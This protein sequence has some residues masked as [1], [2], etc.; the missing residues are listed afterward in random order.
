M[1]DISKIKPLGSNTTYN[2]K[3]NS[4]IANITRSGTTFTATRRDGTTFTF[5]QQ[6]NNTWNS[7]STSQ[8]G[9]VAKAPN[10]TN[11]FLRGD[12]TWAKV[13]WDNIDGKPTNFSPS[14]HT[15]AT[16]LDIDTGTSQ[17]TLAYG[18]KYKLTTG[19][20]S[21]IFTMPSTDDT[22]THWT[23][24]LYLGNSTIGTG[25]VSSDITNGNVYLRLYDE[26]TAR[27]NI[28]IIG[29]GATSV[30]GKNGVITI[31]ST[32]TNTKVTSVDNHYTPTPNTNSALSVSAS[33][34]T[35][36]WDIDVVKAVQLQRDA[37]GHVT[38]ISV[39]SGK[40][41]SNPNTDY[42]VRQTNDNTNA[43]YRLLLSY[44]ANDTE[45]DNISRKNTNLRYNPSINKLSTGNLDLTGNLQVSG[46][47]TLN[48]NTSIENAIIN[49]LL[50]NGNSNFINNVNF[51]QIPTAP[52]ATAGTSTTQIATTEFVT[53][54]V[55]Q[56]FVANDAMVFKGLIGSN[57][58]ITQLPTSGYNA[59]WTYR[60]A[61]AGI[62]A[63]EYCEVGDLL[64]AINDGPASGSSVI[65]TDWGKVEHN[66]DGAVFRGSGASNS[67]VGSSTQP[68]YVNGSGI[69]T[70]ITGAIAN[71]ITGNAATATVLSSSGTTNQFWRGDNRWSDTLG[72]IKINNEIKIKGYG[73]NNNYWHSIKDLATVPLTNDRWHYLPNTTGWIV[74]SATDG[75]GNSTTPIYID[76]G[77]IARAI[78]GTISNN[79]TGNA[80]T[81]TTA[82]NATQLISNN[83][84]DYGWNGINYFNI[85]TSNQSA[86]KVNDT[87]FS[88][89]VWTHILR[90][91]RGDPNGYYTDLAI[92]FDQNSIYYKRIAAGS[93]QNSTTNGGWI[94]VLDQL[95]YTSYTVT[96]T[97]SGASGTWNIN[98]SGNAAAASKL[99]NTSKIGDT[100]KPVYFKADGTP[101]AIN[102]T[103]DKAVPSNAV[104]TDRYVNSATFADD[105]TNTAASPVKMTLTRAGSDTATVTASIPKVSSSS[106][107]VAPKGA[108]VSSQNQSTKFLR[109][110]GTWAAPS[111]TVNT[112]TDTLVKQTAKSDNK[113]YK[114]LFT[115]SDSPT[116]GNANEAAYDTDITINPST[117][118]LTATKFIGSL[119][120]NA[121]T[122]SRATAD[123]NG[124]II[125]STYKTKQT[126]VS[127]PAANGTSISFISSITQDANGNITATKATI[128]TVSKTTNGLVPQLPNE[129]TTTKFLRQDGSWVV[130]AA[131]KS[132]TLTRD[133]ETTIATIGGN[134]IKI[135]LPPSDNT[136]EK[137]KQATSTD[138][139]Y[140]KILVSGGATYLINDN[141][142]E[143]TDSVYQTS[144]VMVQ[145]SSGKLV[146]NSFETNT[147]PSNVGL[148]FRR[149]QIT[150]QEGTEETL[151]AGQPFYGNSNRYD[152]WSYPP[153]SS[154]GPSTAVNSESG[155][156][157]IMN[158]RLA[159][160]STCFKDI[161]MSPNNHRIYTRSVNH[162]A[163]SWKLI[164]RSDI[165]GAGSITQP[166]YIS[167]EGVAKPVNA[168][169][170]N[171][172]LL[173]NT[174]YYFNNNTST[175]PIKKISTQDIPMSDCYSKYDIASGTGFTDLNL[176]TFAP[177]PDT[178]Y[179]LSFYAKANY[180]NIT[181]RTHFYP[182]T[183]ASSYNCQGFSTTA[184]NDG[185]S[186]FTVSTEWKRYWV[187]YKTSASV[188]GTK[189][190]IARLISGTSPGT[191]LR[192]ALP[193]LEVGQ[194]MTPWVPHAN[195][196]SQNKIS[197]CYIDNH[198]L[199]N[200]Q[201]HRIATCSVGTTNYDDRDIILFV[202]KGYLANAFGI[203]K[204]SVRV[205]TNAVSPP[206]KLQAKWLLRHGFSESDCLIGL[207]RN[208]IDASSAATADIY[209]KTST[210]YARIAF[211]ALNNFN[212]RF[213]LFNSDEIAK[214]ENG[215]KIT[216]L[217]NST[218][219]YIKENIM[220]GTT[221]ESIKFKSDASSDTGITYVSWEYAS[222]S[223]SEKS[224]IPIANNTYDLGSS[225]LKWNNI[226]A[227]NFIGNAAT[228]TALAT[229]RTLKV[230][231]ASTSASTVFDGS[232]NINDIGVSGTLPVAQGGT[233]N[234][235]LN[236]N[237]V[238]IGN[239]ISAIK[240][241]S[242]TVDSNGN[243][244]NSTSGA[245]ITTYKVTNEKGSVALYVGQ[246][247]GL[248]DY[249]K[250][251]W[252]ICKPMY[253]ETNDLSDH[254][255]INSWK[256]IGSAR[257]SI[258][259]NNN[260]EPVVGSVEF[261]DLV[262]NRLV[263]TS[264]INKPCAGYHYAN[265]SKIAVNSTS[266]PS[267]NFYVNGTSYFNGN[268]THN[269]F[270]Y[271]ANG[272]NYYI[273]NNATANLK[274][275][276]FAGTSTGETP[277]ENYYQTGAIEIRESNRVRTSQTGTA[278]APRIGFHWGNHSAAS[279]YY[280]YDGKFYLRKTNG[281]DKA[282]LNANLEGN[283]DTATKATQDANGNN[284]INT[285]LTKTAGVTNITWDNT[286]KKLIKTINNS[287]SDIVTLYAANLKLNNT[288]VY[289]T[290]LEIKNIKIGNGS[291]STSTKNV[292]LEYNSTLETLNFVFS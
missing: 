102:Y 57:Q 211:T 46:N 262:A 261:D 208:L 175:K 239:G 95:N 169:P 77:G 243:L 287:N 114:I 105:S 40:L 94:K 196:F 126:A 134:A 48:N 19:G 255:Y 153:T 36:A 75:T 265:A 35:A 26:T 191:T 258:Y 67:S 87:P 290:E 240:T 39:T 43:E 96:K 268:V 119:Q 164:L 188:S 34:A 256:N 282:I 65:N 71:D 199:N 142:S 244:S 80:A 21:I 170:V 3:D 246:A 144:G 14:T 63:G 118:T 247:R 285:Y 252:I 97:G 28:N 253:N 231:L 215:V 33:G 160:N 195:D 4:A 236:E 281:V 173:T 8:A 137:V 171:Q 49:S 55:A 158:L 289:N 154:A 272:T 90:F 68:V 23:T 229:G 61:N 276:V 7:L 234:T 124:N 269:G 25:H 161:F 259:F 6:D 89:N 223:L 181:I 24:H 93:L 209:F 190:L 167:N 32:D 257:K 207:T 38:G 216:D 205:D 103:I 266:E 2:I 122:A 70:A 241:T 101:A 222:D 72:F 20:T 79:T 133:T 13:T 186:N 271:F 88:S 92:P 127:D 62:F 292:K 277:V 130:V 30:T 185:L 78:T 112:N 250:S 232:A 58:L 264:A 27:E 29:T 177:A 275:G 120:G 138:N 288:A 201:W 106:A 203:L 192:V 12:A 50:V 45:E 156:V 15:H 213:T 279:L 98:I 220:N 76:E 224:L 59:G 174:Q 47:A 267:Y 73:D 179:T 146:A 147:I 249:T 129:T 74:T 37:K 283:A 86:A 135:K 145:P 202:H 91:N 31:N 263:W 274:R 219:V 139:A 52:T 41:P 1:A 235:T 189:N 121:A 115:T 9:Y 159:F 107:G 100:N 123:A 270:I 125:T 10:D 291:T 204:I 18:E 109:E 128:P 66:I 117:H 143:R 260:G 221:V 60:V 210:T 178:W 237:K 242:L 141:A 176:G 132:T 228:A 218:E 194:I 198:E 273:D 226:Y 111:Y 54:A 116:S 56:G 64:I 212:K 84:M 82:T 53:N 151:P 284:I 131:A 104:F 278:Y 69:V 183:T 81:A 251:K 200:Y 286:N 148:Q 42:K 172:N 85:F 227:N 206:I 214:T 162:T 166:V 182:N 245:T 238:L 11:K 197:T 17:I 157:N 5:N 22:D 193:K 113:N 280:D 168:L 254:T 165:E 150:I 110:D 152:L 230:N 163:D 225:S 248:Y 136:D 140:R 16:S 180:N 217:A 51:I 184:A 149:D 99:S 44:S 233:G 187:C 83:R 108:A 155:L